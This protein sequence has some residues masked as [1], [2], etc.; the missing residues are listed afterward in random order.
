MRTLEQIKSDLEEALRKNQQDLYQ[1]RQ[2]GVSMGKL[3]LLEKQQEVMLKH[4]S[5]CTLLGPMKSFRVT[6]PNN[7][8]SDE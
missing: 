6:N 4:Y 7:E 5:M 2:D 3:L 1:L 8:E